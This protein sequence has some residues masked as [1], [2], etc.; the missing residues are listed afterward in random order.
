MKSIKGIIIGLGLLT[1]SGIFTIDLLAQSGPADSIVQLTAEA[2]GL[3][4]VSRADLPPFGTYW[5]VMA[6]GAAP[7]PCP[8]DQS[9]PIYA[10][11]D[12][13][14]I[15]DSTSGQTTST[16]D[17]MAE[18]TTVV[19][20]INQAQE[21]QSRRMA[22][23]MTLDDPPTPGEDDGSGGDY[24]NL[25][26]SIYT[27]DTNQLWLELTNIFSGVGYANLHRATNQVY[28]IWGTPDLTVPFAD[29]QVETE[30]WPTNIN[31]MPFAVLTQDRPD[32]FL[33]AQDWTD[34]F[35]NGLPAWWI[36]Y[37]F[38]TLDLSGTNLDTSG[39]TLWHDYTNHSD[40]NTIIFVIAETNTY[41]NT[42]SLSLPLN[43]LGGF[44]GYATVLIND[45]NLADAT[46][47]PFNGSSVI[48][49]LGADGAYNVSV[50]LR[51]FPTNALQTWETIPLVKDT[52]FPRL[53]ITNPVSATVAQTPIQFQGY[54]SEP[55]DTLTYDITNAAGTFTNQPADLTGIFYDPSLLAYTTNYFQSGNLYLAGGANVITLHGTDWAGNTTNVSFTV[56]FTPSTN[57]PVL[58]LFWPEAGAPILGTQVTLKAHVSDP[59][60]AVTAT[61]NGTAEPA[62]V[63]ADGSVW[64][65]NL[66]LNPGNNTV[67]LTANTA[68]GGMT[69]TNFSVSVVTNN[70][71]LSV[72][73]DEANLYQ[74]SI[75]VHGAINDLTTNS[76][77]VNGVK[78]QAW[79][80][81]GSWWAWYA[82][83][84]QVNAY[85]MAD[86]K[87][88]VYQGDP[89]WVASTS[90][91][92]EQPT[93]VV[94][95]SYSGHQTLVPDPQ[96][97][98]NTATEYDNIN[99]SDH[100]GGTLN[101]FYWGSLE[102]TAG[103][104]GDP[105]LDVIGPFAPPWEYASLRASVSGSLASFDNHINTRVMIEPGG[106]QPA[107]TTNLYL[108]L[109][110]AF[111]ASDTNVS[112]L[113]F[114]NL[115]L[116][117]YRGNIGLPPEWLEINGQQLVNTGLTNSIMPFG[118]SGATINA[119]WGATVVS[120]AAGDTP[121]VTPVATQ[122]YKNLDYTFDVQ[123]YPLKLKILDASGNDLTL[124]PNTVIVGQ[125]M[126]FTAKLALNNGTTLTNYPLSDFHWTVPGFTVTNFY[127]STDS[128]QTNGYPILLAA[129]NNQNI[130]FWWVNGATNCSV[131]CSATVLGQTVT[132]SAVF[133][134]LR[135]AGKIF[136]QTG[137]VAINNLEMNLEL[138][139]INAPSYPTAGILFSNTVTMPPGTNYNWGNANYETEWVQLVT[140]PSPM[141]ITT[142]TGTNVVVHTRET[143]GIVLDSAYPYPNAYPFTG[144]ITVDAPFVTLAETNETSASD[145]Q[146]SKMWLMFKPDGGQWVP[147][148]TVSWNWSG[149]ANLS[150]T[151]WLLS[152]SSWSTNPP[153]ADAGTAYP[154]W[155]NNIANT[156]SF[157][158][159]PPL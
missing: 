84:V 149:G 4:L 48:A 33:R 39:N 108:V 103:T 87:V 98:P 114:V 112:G 106:V 20:L 92:Y 99:W 148:R 54:A 137:A 6:R 125:Q 97:Y 70:L 46:W 14:F 62:T 30:V 134:I 76:V 22:R 110:S 93:A 40:P 36:W 32:L 117:S 75:F 102:I 55:L 140:S 25:F 11:T 156:N 7:L 44:P 61:V 150:G 67:T 81:Y 34:V 126:N 8:P 26:Y 130:N 86:V 3:S 132:A 31:S 95:K 82:D 65:Q 15:V 73:L 128:F 142:T 131:Q 51:G 154:T 13:Q 35:T 155:T 58:T 19:N 69:T 28:A 104:N 120:A 94:L 146:I 141:T 1:L 119:F 118:P 96:V 12:G 24:T 21:V 124:Q 107:G 88:D 144:K 143:S 47:L 41:V 23:T 2:R 37:N 18:A 101:D 105:F 52:V 111:E 29:W 45:T 159:N 59:T 90:L 63:A 49:T 50:G 147:L 16:N 122:V 129:T 151:N 138:G 78:A 60:A 66:L 136:A 79:V 158:W 113:D 5:L 123:A 157:G 9:L 77:Y 100:A 68:L 109:A 116:T 64:V 72:S 152:A 89:V 38:H 80:P 153:D 139:F 85:G 115:A 135:P 27:I 91:V 10:I 53:T 74:G 145:T 83:N 17:L 56:N 133:N 42:A 71:G 127:V 43:V 121:D 57:P